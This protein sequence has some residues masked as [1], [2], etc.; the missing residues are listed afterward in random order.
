MQVPGAPSLFFLAYILVFL[1]WASWRSGRRLRKARANGMV[2]TSRYAIWIGTLL[3]LLVLLTLSW[4]VGAGFEYPFLAMPPVDA[5]ALSAA[6]AALVVCFALRSASRMFR[7]EEER[8]SMLV[9]LLAPRSGREWG[10]W[11]LTVLVA[12]VSEEVAYRGI[13]MTI[14]WYSF[15]NPWIAAAICAAGFAAAHALQGWKSGVIIFFIALTMHALVAYTGT[16]VY[17]IVV[18]VVYDLVAGWLIGREA[19]RLVTEGAAA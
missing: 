14:L 9:Y 13:G 17:A 15:G 16:L 6:L 10:L 12:G 5:R 11:T 19:D 2:I 3:N 7:S 1:P 8:R 4:F 18:H